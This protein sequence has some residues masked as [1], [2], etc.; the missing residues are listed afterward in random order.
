M[1]YDRLGWHK[2]RLQELQVEIDRLQ[3][4]VNEAK[5]AM[6]EDYPSGNL[7]RVKRASLDLNHV[8]VKLRRGQRY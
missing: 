4:T 2:E 5:A 1:S 6:K 8:A 7:A 3:A